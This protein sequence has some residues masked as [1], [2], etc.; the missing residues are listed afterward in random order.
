MRHQL[1]IGSN[2]FIHMQLTAKPIGNANIA[3][4]QEDLPVTVELPVRLAHKTILQPNG[5]AT[6]CDGRHSQVARVAAEIMQTLIAYRHLLIEMLVGGGQY[7]A[8]DLGALQGGAYLHLFTDCQQ[9]IP[10][11]GVGLYL[12]GN[13]ER[14]SLVLATRLGVIGHTHRFAP[15]VLAYLTPIP[16]GYFSGNGAQNYKGK[17]QRRNVWKCVKIA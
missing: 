6:L 3:I 8:I 16:A 7:I 4:G 11:G 5:G 2:T 17:E 12:Q 1:W 9:A 10:V 15:A 14:S 13:G